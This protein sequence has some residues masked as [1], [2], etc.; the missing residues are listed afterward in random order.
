MV[1]VGDDAEIAEARD[2]DGGDAC[3]KFR[4]RGLRGR[5]RRVGTSL[6]ERD[7]LWLSRGVVTW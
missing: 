2:G 6:L 4:G 7:V 1:D 5:C 3:L